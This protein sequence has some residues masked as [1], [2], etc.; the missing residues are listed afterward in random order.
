[1]RGGSSLCDKC[2]LE[3][4]D[5]PVDHRIVGD[6]SDDAHPDL[7]SRAEEWVHFVDFSY[8]LCPPAAGDHVSRNVPG[9]A[10]K[11][12]YPIRKEL[13]QKPLRTRRPDYQRELTLRK[14]K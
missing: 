11:A 7:A 3:V 6:E 5:D 4:L 9:L 8:H 10:V 12:S 1:M 2:Q 13:A 14:K